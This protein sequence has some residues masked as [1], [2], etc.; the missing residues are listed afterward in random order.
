MQTITVVD[1]RMGRGKSSAAIQ[2]MNEHKTEKRFMYITPYL[3]E[4]ERIC[5]CCDFDQPDSDPST[6]LVVKKLLKSV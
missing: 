3:T 6:F 2:Y 4:V 5:E 1:A